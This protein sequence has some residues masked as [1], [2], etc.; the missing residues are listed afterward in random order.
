MAEIV[1]AQVNERGQLVILLS[2]DRVINV[3]NVVGP[4]GATGAQ[5]VP[6]VTGPKGRDGADIFV[7]AGPPDP[8]EG[9]PG[10]LHIDNVAWKLYQKAG[11]GWGMGTEMMPGASNL[12]AAVRRF[13]G[14]GGGSP[15][16][17]GMGAPSAGIAA[18]PQ[19]SGGLEPI[20]GNGLPFGRNIWSPVAIDPDGDLMEVTLYFSRAGGNEVYT[21]KVIAFRA[22]TVGN[23][24]IA[25]EAAAP[26]TLSHTVEFDAQV[27]GQ[28]LTLRVRSDV[29]WE[30]IRGSINKL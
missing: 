22:N 18:L 7:K 16:Y 28:E 17:F 2:D 11:T 26:A 1:F 21:C 24:T 6:G 27:N 5:G 12:D 20:V 14:A 13:N 15:R 30:Q 4:A 3:G 23:L 8:S 10:D 9:K 25:W 29:A 19:Q